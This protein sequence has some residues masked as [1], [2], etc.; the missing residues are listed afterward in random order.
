MLK[1][2][3]ALSGFKVALLITLVFLGLFLFNTVLERP[4]F[5]DL[6]DKK[7]VDYILRERPVQPHTD[8]V[9]I[10][11]ID[12]ESVDVLGRWPW[13]RRI[14]AQIV[15]TLNDHY[16]VHTIG[17]D[18]VFS[19][20]EE[21]SG[22]KVTEEYLKKV[23]DLKLDSGRGKEFADFL[24][25][26][27]QD[28]D[29]DAIFGR[30]LAR[31]KNSVLGYFFRTVDEDINN[32][33]KKKDI[34]DSARRIQ[35]S[36]ISAVQGNLLQGTL[37]TGVTVESNIEKI[38]KGGWASGTFN[39][40]PDAEDGTVR[41]V[42][43][44]WQYGENIYPSLDLQILKHY[45]NVDN[46]VVATDETGYIQQFTLG[47]RVV[48]TNFDGS[49]MLNYKGPS[50]TFKHISLIDIL[51]K[52]TPVA[53]LK[54]KIILLGATEVGIFDLRTT[55]VEVNYPGVEVH[56]T[57]IDNILSRTY[58]HISFVNHSLT[59]LLILGIG[60][61]L[62][63]VLPHVAGIYGAVISAALLVVYALAHRWMVDNLLTWTS[64]VYVAI[65]IVVVWGGVT[66]FRFLVTDKDKRYIKNAFQQYLAPEVINQLMDNPDLL[67]LG[68][69]LEVV[70]AFFSD[71]QGFSTISEKLTPPELVN[72][73]QEY[74]TEMS[75]I[76]MKHGGTIDK[77]IGDAIVAFFGAPVHYDDHAKRA[78]EAS[79]E[80]Q[81]RLE[82]MRQEARA[83]GKKEDMMLYQRIGLN[84]GQMVVGNMGSQ[85][86]FNY[87]MMG[88]AV[89]LAARLEGAN[90]FYGT[91][92]MCTEFT[93]AP[94]KE[95][96]VGRELDLIV[97]KGVK[98]PVRVF[99]IVGKRGEVPEEKMKGFQYFDKGLDLYRKQQWDEASKYFSAVF[100]LIPND[101]PSKVFIG[102]CKEFKAAPPAQDWNGAYE[103]HE[104]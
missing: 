73:M 60:L 95:A 72:L 69:E 78:L 97:V 63:F 67:K 30:E 80:M 44:L 53:D 52:K 102:R 21:S 23:K 43:V 74:L 3:F 77:Y 25:R 94:Y 98:T 37:P 96:I 18:I 22:L 55:P 86:R 27:A 83:A 59:A 101:P 29:A 87:T 66:L 28:L 35:G 13:S 19:E 11:T 34:E 31:K 26:T 89:N 61:V 85:S 12:K 41:R 54:D 64:F 32:P 79:L 62:A 16:Q 39:M 5:L 82:A 20:A 50:Q 58:F 65:T 103:A 84:T 68:G 104:K 81:I 99:E 36:E 93:Y 45:L 8:V 7:W 47:Q 49:I 1:R 46:I 57:L 4:S 17:F 76:V 9:V 6:M 71:V 14:M 40:Q 24:N 56:A 92:A 10:G 48:E 70:T 75:N 90:K 15:K 88:N 2:I 91:Y 38:Y 42:H 33:A 51:N 100:K